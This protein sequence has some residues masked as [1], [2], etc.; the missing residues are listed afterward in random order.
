MSFLYPLVLAVAVLVTAGAIGAYVA[1][2]QAG[3]TAHRIT[4]DQDLAAA[5]VDMVRRSRR[6]RR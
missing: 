2:Q 6:R 5:L 4:T 3:V 1:L